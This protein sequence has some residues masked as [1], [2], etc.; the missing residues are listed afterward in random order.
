MGRLD[1]A[2]RAARAAI[3][4]DPGSEGGHA[5]L[6]RACLLARR[7]DDALAAATRGLASNPGSGWLH[8]A[9]AAALVDAGRS[10][11]AIA[12]ADESLALAPGDPAGHYLRSLALRGLRRLEEAR[13]AA[14][15]AVELG[16]E[17]ADFRTHLGDVWLDADAARAEAHYRAALALDP[18]RAWTLNNLGVALLRQGKKADASLAFRSA[19]LVD[20]T[21]PQAK[22]NAFRAAVSIRRGGP[23]ALAG[24]GALW[25]A[26]VAL[27]LHGFVAGW[28]W[29]LGGGF[30]VLVL[31]VGAAAA[32]SR[33]GERRLAATD[34][35]L[36]ELHARLTAD[37]DRVGLRAVGLGRGTAGR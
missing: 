9:C 30:A 28:V 31:Q 13:A 7:V 22:L 19:I 8:R 10:C 25:L 12:A 5:L 16:P 24:V 27:M 20:P 2:E 4:A 17:N 11:E 15:V 1:H 23:W 37:L 34:P 21:F 3:A 35:E 29:E 32:L 18:E 26:S 14:M 33:A 36:L 6:S